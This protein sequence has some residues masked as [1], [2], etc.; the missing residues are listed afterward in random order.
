MPRL[1]APHPTRTTSAC[2]SLADWTWLVV[3]LVVVVAV[4]G[5]NAIR[6]FFPKLGRL[7]EAT[8]EVATVAKT[9]TANWNFILICSWFDLL[10]YETL[11]VFGL[12]CRPLFLSRWTFYDNNSTLVRFRLSRK[13]RH[14]IWVYH[15]EIKVREDR[16]RKWKEKEKDL[17][18]RVPI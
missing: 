1:G 17:L 5:A 3:P 8:G 2:P 18:S 15:E 16:K 14:K 6:M 11:C 4:R 12:S 13:I 7:N 9:V 10:C